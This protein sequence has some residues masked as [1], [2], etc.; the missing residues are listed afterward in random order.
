MTTRRTGALAA[1]AAG[2]VLLAGLLGGCTLTVRD[3]GAGSAP[4]PTPTPT[5]EATSP[6][7][8]PTPTP[9][10]AGDGT[11]GGG[12]SEGTGSTASA[13][14][15]QWIAAATTTQA[16]TPDL[17]VSATGSVVRV[18]GPC[19]TLTVKVDA[20]V[21]VADDVR[22]LVVTGTGTVVSALQVGSVA[23]SG[24]VNVIQWS[25][26]APAVDDTGTANTIGRT[27]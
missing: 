1:L 24:D 6:V 23:V 2:G 14:R 20:G 15:E 5:A 22:T 8:S 12:A 9:T 13:E 17:T 7:A 25:G 21:V 18:E 11:S 3:P 26:T 10:P 16:C 27:R 4:V 19:D